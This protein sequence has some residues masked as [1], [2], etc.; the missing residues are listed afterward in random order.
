MNLFI[1][2]GFDYLMFLDYID[3]VIIGFIEIYS[4]EN[5]KCLFIDLYVG[6]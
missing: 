1:W 5:N 2:L 6:L 4:Y 3:W